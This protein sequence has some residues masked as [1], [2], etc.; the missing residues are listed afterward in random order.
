METQFHLRSNLQFCF[1]FPF[2]YVQLLLL[3]QVYPVFDIENLSLSHIPKKRYPGSEPSG[4]SIHRKFATTTPMMGAP[5]V[6]PA[7]KKVLEVSFY[8]RNN[9]PTV[10]FPSGYS[11]LGTVV[12]QFAS[13][14]TLE[15]QL[16]CKAP[17]SL[18][19]WCQE[20]WVDFIPTQ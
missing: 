12:C 3:L 14:D 5:L 19:Q 2:D 20:F 7:P 8:K 9:I 16:R 13:H 10:I 4:M 11:E 15:V 6:Q 18:S 17:C 1:S